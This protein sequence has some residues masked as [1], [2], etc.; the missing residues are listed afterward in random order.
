MV[1]VVGAV[2]EFAEG[3]GSEFAFAF[4]GVAPG[5]AYVASVFGVAVEGDV[6]HVAAGFGGAAFGVEF[7]EVVGVAGP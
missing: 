3:G 1:L 6:L 2:N 7:V 5:G 4:E